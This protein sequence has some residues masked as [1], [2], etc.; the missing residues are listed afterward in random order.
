MQVTQDRM[1][2]VR[3][4]LG[5]MEDVDIDC[6]PVGA[7]TADETVRIKWVDSKA[8][9]GGGSGVNAGVKS[10]VDGRPMEGIPSV[11]IAVQSGRDVATKHHAIRWTEVFIISNHR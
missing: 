7:A 1:M 10:M 5:K 6:G 4:Q 9:G 3:K 11:R 2:E 8:D